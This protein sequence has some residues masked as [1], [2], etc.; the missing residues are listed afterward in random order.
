MPDVDERE[1][2]GT[3]VFFVS[4]LRVKV[5]LCCISASVC[6]LIWMRVMLLTLSVT[7][8]WELMGIQGK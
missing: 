5:I 3:S 4:L 1:A 2:N 8:G 7:A 6:A